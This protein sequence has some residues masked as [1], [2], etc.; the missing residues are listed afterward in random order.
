MALK[1]SRIFGEELNYSS[2]SINILE[3]MLEYYHECVERK[4]MDEE[5]TA[6]IACR[7]GAY[8]G[9][10]LLRNKFAECGFEWQYEEEVPVIRHKTEDWTV[11]PVS[12]VYKRLVNSEED[13]V[14]SFYDIGIDYFIKGNILQ[15]KMCHRR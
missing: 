13:S 10:T 4:L 6:E 9:E 8:L 15:I 11:R 12:K 3:K 7:F 2:E 14:V 1:L 5:Q